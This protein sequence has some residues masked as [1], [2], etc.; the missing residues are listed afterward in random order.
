M[1]FKVF[2]GYNY[3]RLPCYKRNGRLD[4]IGPYE[5][6]SPNLMPH[7]IVDYEDVEMFFEMS[8]LSI[9]FQQAIF[10]DYPG[11]PKKRYLGVYKMNDG[12]VSGKL[13]RD[14]RGLYRLEITVFDWK[15]LLDMQ[16]LEDRLWSDDTIRPTVSFED[17]EEVENTI[18]T[19]FAEKVVVKQNFFARSFDKVLDRINRSK[20]K[21]V[22]NLN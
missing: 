21:K 11:Y 2:F 20:L 14:G 22:S 8:N 12:Q 19:V 16:T 1:K 4:F 7:I 10:V 17:E 5:V 3:D 9:A 6:I 13:K 15:Y 18:K